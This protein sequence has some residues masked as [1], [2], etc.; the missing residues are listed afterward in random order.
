MEAHIEKIRHLARLGRVEF[1]DGIPSDRVFLKGVWSM[2]TFGLVLEGAIDYQAERRRL[3][4]EVAQTRG[5]IDKIL[6]KINNHEFMARAPESV[7]AETRAR[8]VDFVERLSKLESNLR[9]LPP[10]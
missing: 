2:G 4:K 9:H 7:V 5:D 8:H 3:A 6:K 10:G 1:A